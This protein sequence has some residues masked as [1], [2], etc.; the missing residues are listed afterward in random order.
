MHDLAGKMP[1]SLG[2]CLDGFAIARHDLWRR[3][4]LALALLFIVPLVLANGA[5]AATSDP[6]VGGLILAN[7]IPDDVLFSLAKFVGGYPGQA[8]DYSAVMATNGFTETM[9]GSYGGRDLALAYTASLVAVSST[10]QSFLWTGGGSYGGEGWSASGSATLSWLS[11]TTFEIAYFH[12]L[13]VGANTAQADTVISG[14][15][16]SDL[17]SYTGTTG[18]FKINDVPIELP[19]VLF[20]SLSIVDHSIGPECPAFHCTVVNNDI[21]HDMLINSRAESAPSAANEVFLAGTI[22][23]V[24]VPEPSTLALFSVAVL[25]WLRRQA[26]G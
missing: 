2:R 1:D 4:R 8:L 20:N 3:L 19:G 21:H 12:A 24:S 9:S 22:E 23:V 15:M 13:S 6:R 11:A 18:V 26:R 14:S 5:R 17:I 25:V 16:T 10:M 7:T